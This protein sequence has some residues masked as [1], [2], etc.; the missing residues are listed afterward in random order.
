MQYPEYAM[1][2][3]DHFIHTI[4]DPSREARAEYA[5]T[6]H[7]LMGY[8]TNG[9][10]IGPRP[11]NEVLLYRLGCNGVGILPS[12]MGGRKIA[13]HCGEK[14]PPS[15]LISAPRRLALWRPRRKAAGSGDSR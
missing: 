15:I 3:I 8:T 7:G 1:D 2:I 4:Y 12:I 14:I 5:F 9:I 10:R 6:W 13:A 11:Q